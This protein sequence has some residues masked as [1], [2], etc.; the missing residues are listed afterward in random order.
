MHANGNHKKAVVAILVLDKTAFKRKTVII[1]KQGHYIRLKESIQ[2]KK[3]TSVNI[4]ARKLGMPK[5]IK[6]ILTYL[7]KEID[8]K[9]II[10]RDLNMPLS[11]M[12]RSSSQKNQ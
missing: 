12:Y 11:S 8:S 10:V 1:D 7:K 5:Y 3:I 2:Q 9:T 4:Y 6:Q